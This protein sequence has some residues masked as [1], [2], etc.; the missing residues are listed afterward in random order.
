MKR[1]LLMMAIVITIAIPAA[2][3]GQTAGAGSFGIGVNGGILLPVSGDVTSDSSFNDYFK[4]GPDL[5]LH[6]SFVPVQHLT[7]EA[8]FDYAFMKLK[9]E[10]RPDPN[11]EP[12][13]SVPYVYLNAKW[14]I[15]A[16]IKS[17]KNIVNP[18]L[19]AGGGVYFW[20]VTDDGAGGD[21]IALANGEEFKKS[22]FG[23]QLGAGSE[24]FVSH[25]ISVFAEGKYHLIFTED[26]EKFG[27][28]FANLSAI[29]VTG[30]LTFYFP[31]G[32]K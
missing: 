21:A 20:K 10:V 25:N 32:A 18:Y 30:G 17:E 8:G 7:L 27:D 5:G 6:L 28:N 9:D 31:L 24:F 13:F 11:L 26:T 12:Y 14:N 15:G 4:A 2:H 1:S 29:S 3:A 22:S 23:L 19:L 16:L